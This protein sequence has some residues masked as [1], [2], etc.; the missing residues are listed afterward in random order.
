M[1]SVVVSQSEMFSKMMTDAA[2]TV[3]AEPPVPAQISEQVE[4]TDGAR[5][6]EVAA[7]FDDAVLE[8]RHLDNPSAGKVS[9]VTKGLLGSAGAALLGTFAMFADSYSQVAAE[10]A[11]ADS[12][13]TISAPRQS[14]TRGSGSTRDAAAGGLLFYGIGALLYGLH[15]ASSERRENEFS[16]GSA[17]GAT[18]KV[19]SERLPTQLFPLVRS[20]GSEY[21]F[22]FTESMEGELTLNGKSTSLRELRSQARPAA[23][24]EGALAISIPDG[25][26]LSVNHQSCSF[27]VRS[28]PR[29]RRY[30]VPLRVD[31]RTQSYT[32]AVLAGAATMMA[33]MFAVPPDPRSLA[34][35]SFTNE[36]LAHYLVKAPEVKDEPTPWL[37]KQ[38]EQKHESS[39]GKSA[40]GPS[41]KL[42]KQE[43][44]KQSAR[45]MVAGPKD[46]P[47]PK[48][49]RK[50]AEEAVKNQG[51]LGI[52]HSS[53]IKGM[54]ALMGSESALGNEA[55]NALGNMDG[56]TVGDAW[57]NNGM[58]YVGVGHGGDGTGDNTIGGG[59]WGTLGRSGG[60]PNYG[61]FTPSAKLK[62]HRVTTPEW[63]IGTPE[64]KGSLD[65]ELIRRVIRQHMNEV[66]FCYEKELTRD[67][68]LQGRVVVK[69][70]IGGMG[71]VMT[72]LVESS[73]LRAGGTDG[74]I[75]NAVR[76]WQFP[77]PQGGLVIVSYPFVLK[78]SSGE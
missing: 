35:D 52:L 48:M 50:L 64:I 76:R 5:A 29:P 9:R 53:N 74:C 4:T 69:F 54:A 30:P 58:G 46:N 13:T 40:K 57:G 16:I 26:K 78:S 37:N 25:A 66:K 3:L 14:Q 8:V 65:K 34:L 22:L 51:L 36:Q 55:Q 18:F 60:N 19:D 39:G 63:S 56:R 7:L 47:D 71:N 17:P 41:G 75:A 24:V 33:V 28:V 2:Q 44:P 27:L 31:W 23:G 11:A 67:N 10:K 32:A 6:I 15:R 49:S 59:P 68:S 1:S 62:D 73:T 72:S 38:L 42:G 21:E 20:T 61:R 77:K 45:Y 12:A 70:S 43:A